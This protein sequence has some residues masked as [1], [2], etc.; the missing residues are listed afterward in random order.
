MSETFP[1]LSRIA[2]LNS[3]E[4]MSFSLRLRLKSFVREVNLSCARFVPPEY[5]KISEAAKA[6][7]AAIYTVQTATVK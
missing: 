6:R 4:P 3:A 7:T 2:L 1:R 5:S